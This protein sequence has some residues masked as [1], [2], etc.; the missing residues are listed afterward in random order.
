MLG[1]PL[2]VR[3]I[4]TNLLRNALEHSPPDAHIRIGGRVLD[5][6][7]ET[8]VEDDGPGIPPEHLPR[9]FERFYRTD[10]SR[11]RATGG[12]GL[13][14]AIV[15]RLVEAQGGRVGAQNIT[16][17]GARFSFTLPTPH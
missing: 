6:E 14:L 1:D 17:A 16:G 15:Q 4:L 7:L 3:Q 8:W 9:L 2:R 12:A 10:P 13:G 5:G 11:Q